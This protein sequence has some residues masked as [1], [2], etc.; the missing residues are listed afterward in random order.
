[1]L[2]LVA[3]ILRYQG[4]VTAVEYGLIE[5][6]IA[7]AAVVFMRYKPL[8]VATLSRSVTPGCLAAAQAG[9][10]LPIEKPQPQRGRTPR[11]SG[12]RF[13]HPAPWP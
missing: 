1:M 11:Q 9:T 6:L 13:C 7:V 8:G 10:T 4:G 12:L 2:T 3:R 5:A